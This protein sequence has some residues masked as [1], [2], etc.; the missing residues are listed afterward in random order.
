MS[1]A[2]RVAVSIFIVCVIFGQL[3]VCLQ[4]LEA[5]YQFEISWIDPA[6]AVLSSL[7]IFSL[8]IEFSCILDPQS[9]VVEYGSQLLAYPAVLLG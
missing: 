5:I 4:S 7:A 1:R 2:R 8:D 3:V 9:H 6:K